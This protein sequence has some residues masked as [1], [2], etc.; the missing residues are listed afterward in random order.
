MPRFGSDKKALEAVINKVKDK[1]PQVRRS[2][3]SVLCKWLENDS[4]PYLIVGLKDS[5]RDV[6]D[7]VT[8]ALGNLKDQRAAYPLVE[9]LIE[10]RDEWVKERMRRA[11]WQITGNDLSPEEW[12]QWWERKSK[13][14][15]RK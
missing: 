10:E 5:N 9:A 13:I 14:T 3:L 15:D 12:R 1:Y 7:S 11:L 6:R 2:A 4:V 8:F